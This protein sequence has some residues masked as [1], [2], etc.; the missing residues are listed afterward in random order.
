MRTRPGTGRSTLLF[1]IS[2]TTIGIAREG[3]L[4]LVES[5]KT[6]DS[7]A[8][9]MLLDQQAP[10]NST[11]ADGATALHWAAHRDD[12]RMADMLLGA[13]VNATNELG[14]APLS[15]A[16][17]N[18]S[19]AMVE[20]LLTAGANANHALPTGVTPLMTCARSGGVDAVRQLLASGANVNTHE[21]VRGQTALMWAVAEKHVEVGNALIAAGADV[22]AKSRSGFTPLLFAAQQGDVESARQYGPVPTRRGG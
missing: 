13:D 6:G 10:V 8:V 15:L 5:A 3:D 19:A 21:T 4:R 17:V 7:A 9:Q 18:G 16:C 1:A 11:E 2:I 20:R 14:V 22:R 12:S